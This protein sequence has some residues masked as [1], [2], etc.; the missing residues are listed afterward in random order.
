[1][2]SKCRKSYS[3]QWLLARKVVDERRIGT[4]IDFHINWQQFGI[5]KMLLIITISISCFSFFGP[6][7]DNGLRRAS[8]TI[9]QVAA[10]APDQDDSESDVDD[11]TFPFSIFAMKNSFKLM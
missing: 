1:M 3:C 5:G 4:I 9:G 11:C 8:A 10:D 2:H 6:V 7:Y